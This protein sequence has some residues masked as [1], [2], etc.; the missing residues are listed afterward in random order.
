MVF[1]DCVL[2]IALKSVFYKPDAVALSVKTVYINH[3]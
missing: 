1:E 3:P 2:N